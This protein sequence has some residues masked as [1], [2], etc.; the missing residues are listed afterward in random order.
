LEIAARRVIL[1][2]P[3]DR[4]RRSGVEEE[5]METVAV[6]LSV[7]SDRVAEFEEGFRNHEL[8][9]WQD[10][11]ERG[12]MLSAT[13][14]R[15]DISSRS[16]AGAT[17]YLIVVLF[18]TGEGHHEHDGDPRFA[19]WNAMADEYQIADALAFGGETILAVG[20]PATH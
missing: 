16:V 20:A 19:A 13:L 4:S 10:F 12:V 1:G 15:M 18:A 11:N 6:V 3:S 8:P 2:W 9:I 7:G 14:S 5:R 17:Q